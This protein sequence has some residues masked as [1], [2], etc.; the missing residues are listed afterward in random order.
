MPI[1]EFYWGHHEDER[2]L[3]EIDADKETVEKLLNE[4]RATD[5]G[6]NNAD[7]CDFL[8]KKGIKAKGLQP[9]HSIYF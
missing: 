6:Y 9:E 1:Y 8:E 3:M 7:W 2:F 5:E 4:Y